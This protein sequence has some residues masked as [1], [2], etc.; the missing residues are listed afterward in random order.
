M[1]RLPAHCSHSMSAPAPD[2]SALI[3]RLQQAD[4]ILL[5]T[6]V[7]P[8]SDAIGSLLGLAGALRQLGKIVTASCADA[9]HDRF[10]LLPGHA[11]VVT[12]APGTFDLVV[13][14]DCGDELRLGAIWT[15][16]SDPKPFLVN[17]DHHISNTRF[18]QIVW[19]EPSAA[20]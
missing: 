10:E 13:A 16:L 5:I 7:S 1:T 8:D 14:L 6:H 17:I 9:I 2:F 12:Q 15:N 20:S 18:G 4:R 19:V 11:E 3:Q